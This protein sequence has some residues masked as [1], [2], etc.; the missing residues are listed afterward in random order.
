MKKTAQLGPATPP[1]GQPP[2]FGRLPPEWR[3]APLRYLVTFSGGGTPDKGK[4][5]YWNGTIPW[6]SPKDMK[7]DAIGESEDHITEAALDGTVVQLLPPQSVLVVVRGMILARTLPVA[8]TTKAVT[9]NQDI[10]ALRC[11]PSLL[12]RFLQAVLQGQSHWLLSQADQSAHG[13]KKLETDV[14]RQFETPRPS[15][16][17]QQQV[18]SYLERETGRIDALIAAKEHLLDLLAEKQKALV[19]SAVM[20]G[21]DSAVA[22]R[23][24]GVEWMPQAPAHWA[25]NR[26]G[27]LFRQSK[28]L[29]F[30]DL[31]ILSVYREYGVIERSARDDNANRIPDDL[32]KYQLVEA[33]DLVINKMK[34][35]QGSLGISNYQGITSPDYV[36]FRPTHREDPEFLHFLLRTQLLTTVY[37]SMSNGIRT[38]QWRIEPDRLVGLR[39]FLPPVTEQREIVDHISREAAKLERLRTATQLSLDLIRERR[40]ALIAAAVTGQLDAG[41]AA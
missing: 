33:G 28:A 25:P 40:A 36:V 39:I 30:P 6:V 3:S 5:E 26:L 29:G 34:A 11:G 17:T 22:T 32:E 4:P 35:W 38:G 2:W 37:L 20:R 23:A 18:V 10:K 41:A 15:L 13:T 16:K 9:I 14:L 21:L 12:P 7:R 24:T 31:T 1:E 27:R 19:A 8:V